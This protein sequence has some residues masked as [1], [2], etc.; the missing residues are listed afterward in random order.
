MHT[1]GR[2]SYA[3]NEDDTPSPPG[4][5]VNGVANAC[6]TRTPQDI[7]YFM[8]KF[9]LNP[10]PMST[11]KSSNNAN[12]HNF[13]NGP[14]DGPGKYLSGSNGYY[15][16]PSSGNV[17]FTVEGQE[18][19]P[20][21]NNQALF[22]PE[23]CEVDSC[24]EHIGQG[25]G[26]PHIH[27]DSYGSTCLYSS[28]NY[29]SITSHPPLIGISNDGYDI[30]GRYLSTQA[31]GYILALDDCGGHSHDGYG[32]HYHTQII[33][34]NVTTVQGHM[35]LKYPLSTPGVYQCWKG[36]I[37]TIPNFWGADSQTID[38]AYRPCCDS[39]S[40][41][42]ASGYYNVDGTYVQSNIVING[43]STSN[44]ALRP[45][46]IPLSSSGNSYTFSNTYT[47]I[48]SIITSLSIIFINK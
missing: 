30:Y 34:G 40:F 21:Y 39:T 10:I 25:G 29:T 33:T 46:A 35:G 36:N 17:G 27:G 3:G 15:G 7:Q 11:S 32:Y 41:Y 19:F 31:P 16:L 4:G 9:P 20:V 14:G 43:V 12:L 47:I 6:V 13:P 8:Q 38:D 18:I 48:I 1:T 44:P 42:A 5:T 2:A 37:S 24:N 45:A 26:W 28:K 22:T 23:K